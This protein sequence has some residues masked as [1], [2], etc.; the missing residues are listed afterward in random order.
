MRIFNT[1]LYAV[2]P[3]R[4]ASRTLSSQSLTTKLVRY[5]SA[6]DLHARNQS[7]TLDQNLMVVDVNL[8]HKL[9]T[10]NLKT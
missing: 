9:R 4:M 5:P 7:L 6:K 10:P 2:G 3:T 8:P 1:E